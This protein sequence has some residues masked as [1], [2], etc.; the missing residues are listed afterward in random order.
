MEVLEYIVEGSYSLKVSSPD[1]VRPWNKFRV[2]VREPETYCNYSSGS[3][4]R[5]RLY[6]YRSRQLEDVQQQDMATTRP[7][8]FETNNYNFSL[9]F[10]NIK[11]G[12]TPQIIHPDKSIADMFNHFSDKGKVILT[13]A[14]NF[15]NEPGR[16]CLRYTYTSTDN[17]IHQDCIEFDVVSP[18]LDTKDD[19]KQIIQCIYNEYEAHVFRYLSLTFQQFSKG[20]EVNNELIWL[21]IFKEIIDGYLH[22]VHYI[23]NRPHLRDIDKTDYQKAERIKHWTPALAEKFV[24]DFR[25]NSDVALHSH[26]R[27]RQTESTEDTRENRF[28]KYTVVKISQQ[29]SAVIRKIVADNNDKISQ[30]EKEYLDEKQKELKKLQKASLFRTVGRFEGFR[31]ESIVL[32][33]RTGYAQVYRYWLMLKNGLDL[34]DGSMAIG[35]LPI[36]RLYEL[37]CFLKMKQIVCS[38]LGIDPSNKEDLRYIHEEKDTMLDPF[39]DNDMTHTVVYDNP[40]NDDIITLG[41]QYTYNKRARAEQKN[42]NLEHVHSATTEQRPDIVLQIKKKNRNDFVLTYLFDAKYRVL[43]DEEADSLV[44]GDMPVPDTLNQMHRYRDALYYGSDQYKQE[45]KEV[46]GAY[47]LFPGRINEA[48]ELEKWNNGAVNV[49][50]IQSIKEVNIG[51]FPLLPNKDSSKEGVLLNNFLGKIINDE[52]IHD[53]IIGSIPQKGLSYTDN[54]DGMVLI[55][56]VPPSLKEYDN[57]M[58][59]KATMY[60][61]GKQFPSTYN[62]LSFKYFAPCFDT[63]TVVGYYDITGIKTATKDEIIENNDTPNDG[64]RIFFTLG[65]YHP[66]EKRSIPFMRV[67][68]Q[69]TL[70]EIMKLSIV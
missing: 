24:E 12:T 56:I 49:D 23:L 46:I 54:D 53:Q 43:G 19:L 15:L 55:G 57:F 52:S 28:L 70:S 1:I 61:S 35:V 66:L 34:F 64:V 17:V 13:G 27:I 2:R 59:G 6:D 16:F 4:G 3:E 20:R 50:Y 36:W 45:A 21:S 41:Y 22:A 14:I 37:W 30:E 65:T 44:K 7:V 33:Q 40:Q 25:N 9:Y 8:F 69:C 5:L 38:I 29:L 60:Y 58:A 10:Q 18:K 47:I 26:Y 62:V 63:K 51:A 39:T 67:Y 31:Q 42:T 68:S 48:E 11:E 32:Q